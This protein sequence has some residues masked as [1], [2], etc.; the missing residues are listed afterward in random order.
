VDYLKDIS[1]NWDDSKFTDD[2]SGKYIVM[3]RK[4]DNVFHIVRINREN[5]T[6]EIEIDLSI[7]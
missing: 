7:G 6:R 2:Y 1:T 4:K 5:K 3:A